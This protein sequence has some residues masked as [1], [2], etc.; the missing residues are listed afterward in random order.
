[1]DDRLHMAI[2]VRAWLNDLRIS[3]PARARLAA[4]AILALLDE[5]SGLGPPLLAQAATEIW[6]HDPGDRFDYAYQRYL[7]LLTRVRRGVADV[8]TSRKRFELQIRQLELQ[9]AKLADQSAKALEAG[10]DDLA[11]EAGVRRSAAAAQLAEMRGQCAELQAQEEKMTMASQRLQARVDAFRTRKETFKATYRAA[12]SGQ[13]VTEAL[14]SIGDLAGDADVDA[15]A[16]AR[17]DSAIAAGRQGME[18]MLESARSFERE[19]G[20]GTDERAG[21]WLA[22][23]SEDS[24]PGPGTDSA[25]GLMELRPGAPADYGTRILLTIQPTGMCVRCCLWLAN[26]RIRPG[27]TR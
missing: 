11:Q 1:M 8:A 25:P 9:T 10:R 17:V 15:V 3:R 7:E 16:E 26:A 22:G 27:T 21:A 13:A 24:A 4:E 5:G 19:A 12:R 23:A 2:E 20:T 14:V 6:A 18:E